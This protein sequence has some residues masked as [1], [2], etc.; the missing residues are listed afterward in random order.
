[1]AKVRERLAVNKQR[2]HGLH[3]EMFH[4]KWINEVQSK[5]E[6][7]VDVSKRFAVLEDL[8]TEIG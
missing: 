3:V 8:Y 4:L 1:M 5:E 2:S 6:Y 7:R